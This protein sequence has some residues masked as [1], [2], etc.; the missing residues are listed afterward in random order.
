MTRRSSWIYRAASVALLLIGGGIQ[1]Q[2]AGAADYSPARLANAERKAAAALDLEGMALKTHQLTRIRGGFDPAPGV[3]VNFGF[4]QTIFAD[5]RLIQSTIVPDTTIA[6]SPGQTA[7]AAPAGAATTVAAPLL[8]ADQTPVTVI[9]EAGAGGVTNLFRNT[10]NGQLVQQV[11][12]INIGITGLNQMLARQN[13]VLT[14]ANR[15]APG[16]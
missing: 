2:A 8:P 15:L 11:T 13:Q 1:A 12:S 9:S 4:Q 16:R 14:L 5:H 6:I 7:V 3:T 10:A